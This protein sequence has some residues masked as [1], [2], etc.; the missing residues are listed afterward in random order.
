MK[1]HFILILTFL[2]IQ[3]S[4]GQKET[5]FVAH[6]GASY[7]APENT[8]ASINLAWELGAKAAEC[9][10]MLTADKQVIVFHDKKGKRLTGHDFEVKASDYEDIKDYPII[11]KESNDQQYTGET[12]PLLSDVLQTIRDGLQN[13]A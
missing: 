12:I 4:Y 7:L 5:T 3:L 10:I 13:V 9:D 8:L 11:L 2:A 6:R 1:F